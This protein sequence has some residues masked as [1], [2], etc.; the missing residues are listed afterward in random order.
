MKIIFDR[1][2]PGSGTVLIVQRGDGFDALYEQSIAWLREN[3]DR[4]DY[5]TQGVT[6]TLAEMMK[7]KKPTGSQ[8]LIQFRD[9]GDAT[10]WKI[11]FS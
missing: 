7:I 8:I 5:Y 2:Y 1:H 11:R 3:L 10:L 6:H 9:D 4:R